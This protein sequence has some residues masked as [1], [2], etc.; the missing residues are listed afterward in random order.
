M[1][2]SN[3]IAQLE[4][5]DHQKTAAAPTSV[6]ARL[7]SVLAE[8]LEK[9]AASVTPPSA[10]DDPVPGLMK[11]ASQ[12]AGAE[13][14][15]ELAL[16]NMMGQAFADGAIAKF[17]AYDAQVKIAMAQQENSSQDEYLLKSAAS[18]GYAD[19]IELAQQAYNEKVSS[20]NDE[21]IVKQAAEQGYSDAMQKV[22]EAQ[23]EE[24]FNTQVNEIHKIACGEFLK[25]A[26]ETEMLLNA[27]R[28]AQ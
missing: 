22:A 13:Q 15:T 16:A 11:M 26:A 25:G 8:T 10:Q 20:T 17:A 12:L 28:A 1:D 5:Q 14:E 27:V 18:Q 3:V 4:A 7:Q 23:Y 6:D 21:Y 2:L 24:G 19:A 9:S